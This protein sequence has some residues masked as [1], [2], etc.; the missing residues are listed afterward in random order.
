[1]VCISPLTSLMIDQKAKLIARKVVAEFVGE[2]QTAISSVIKGE[3][4]LVLI[5]PESILMNFKFRNMLLTNQY[6]QK[7]S[8][9]GY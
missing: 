1:M 6:K 3:V 5:S 4:Q 8:C 9:S 7:F 2:T